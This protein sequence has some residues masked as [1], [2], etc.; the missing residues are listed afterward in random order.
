LKNANFPGN[1]AKNLLGK[2]F[3]IYKSQLQGASLSTRVVVRMKLG[4]QIPKPTK[5]YQSRRDDGSRKV[6][7]DY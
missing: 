2:H 1:G 6:E 3:N 7:L 4:F 5:A